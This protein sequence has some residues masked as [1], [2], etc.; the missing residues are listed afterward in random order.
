[1]KDTNTSITSVY[2]SMIIL[3]LVYFSI[4]QYI[5][6]YPSILQYTWMRCT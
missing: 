6:E 3:E 1:M 4:F 5:L 2:F